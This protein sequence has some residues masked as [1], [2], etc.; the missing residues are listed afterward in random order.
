MQNRVRRREPEARTL[1]KD[2]VFNSLMWLF[3]DQCE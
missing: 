2:L 3:L 1:S